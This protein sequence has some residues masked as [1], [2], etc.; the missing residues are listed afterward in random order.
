MAHSW[1]DNTPWDAKGLSV[2]DCDGAI[3]ASC[4]TKDIA[5]FVATAPRLR[6]ALWCLADLN[7][8]GRLQ[9]D[10]EDWAIVRAI[11]LQAGDDPDTIPALP[12]PSP[13]RPPATPKQALEALV[14]SL[15]VVRKMLED[16]GAV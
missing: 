4:A 11:L 1:E 7:R 8:L 12:E 3:V 2:R 14:W 10:A 5:R 13:P 16:S 15:G 6:A 9:R